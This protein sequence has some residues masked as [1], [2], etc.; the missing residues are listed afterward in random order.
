MKYF[1]I[2]TVAVLLSCNEN[3]KTETNTTLTDSGS[4]TITAPPVVEDSEITNESKVEAIR[5][6]V[7]SINNETLL[8]QTFNW[9][10]PSCADV[11]TIRYFLKDDEIKKVVETGFIGDGGWTKEYYYDKGKFIFSFDQYI[12]GPAGMPHDTNEVR[13]YVD[14]DT[15]VLQRKDDKIVKGVSKDLNPASREYR[16]LEALKTKNFGAAL[17][18]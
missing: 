18:D 15:L 6:A 1:L 5:A 8:V 2:L 3:V 16:I 14:A 17:C 10:H 4:T 7:Q 11:G 12:G 9:S 13:I